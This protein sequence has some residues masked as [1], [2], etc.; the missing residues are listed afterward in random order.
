[1]EEKLKKIFYEFKILNIE[2][3]KE[4]LDIKTGKEFVKLIKILEKLTRENFIIQIKNEKF[5]YFDNFLK[6]E[7]IIKINK[8]GFGFV[9]CDEIS[10]EV[11]IAKENL[12]SAL[13]QDKVKIIIEK[14]YS[15]KG[16][17]E[18]KVIEILERG[19]KYTV[20]TLTKAKLFSFVKSDD[21]SIDRH[22][23]IEKK[24][25]K[26]LI[27]GSK[28]IVEITD[29]ANSDDSLHKGIIIKTIGHKD[30]PGIDILSTA[31]KHKIPVEFKKEVIDEINKISEKVEN[32]DS[33]VDLRSEHVVTIDG[34]DSKDLDDAISVIK[35]SDGYNLKVFIADVSRYV[36]ENSY[37]DK[38]AINRGCSVYL[39]NTV[40]PMLPR[41]LSN[42]LCS[43]NP[44]KERYTICC[45][46]DFDENAI[47][48]DYEIYPAIIESKGKLTYS[49]VNS[50]YSNDK[51][52]LI[53]YKNHLEMLKTAKKLSEKIRKNREKRGA[54]EFLKSES[55]I[56]LNDKNEVED[57]R[58]RERGIAEK[59]IEDFMISANEVVAE[60]FYWLDLPFIYRVHEKPKIEK[61][62]DFFDI[63]ASLGYRSNVN[64]KEI[65]PYMLANMLLK[66]KDT[67]VET[68]L[69]T[70]LLR[71]MNQAK[72]TNNNIGH[73]ALSSKYYTHFTSPIRRYPDLLVHRMIREFIFNKKIIKNKDELYESIGE[74]AKLSTMCEKRAV[75]CEREVEQIKKC[76]YMIQYQN[77]IFEG[78]ISS[79]TKF[80]LFISLENTIEGLC[81]IKNITDDYY[82]F[83]E[84]K[85]LLIGKRKGKIYKIGDKVKV[86]VIDVDIEEKNIDFK[87]IKNKE[88]FINRTKKI[89]K[90]KRK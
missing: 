67:K 17:L 64:I 78:I 81:H 23:K 70:V 87:I 2:K 5:V 60:H 30:D 14:N 16:S 48:K 82:E 34:E 36:K 88:K 10:E 54:I 50:V 15:K 73:F 47:I 42:D 3:I 69:S 63:S 19:L 74:L 29:F 85:L 27:D 9:Y 56:I 45:E 59:L 71:T 44:N 7:G 57:I 24:Y 53:E 52:I 35:K 46:I 49:K 12:N 25:T 1:M 80:G 13:P 86:K 18:G 76:E 84:K 20:G 61:L 90:R 58:L 4:Y 75:D 68:M 39:L 22:I 38:E 51:D 6:L 32:Y 33:Y 11:Y 8:K 62:R 65:K 77:C 37:I 55:K 83:D 89:K 41:K 43:L 40:I 26:N 66:F 28:V 79:V 21:N 72:Y 31:Y